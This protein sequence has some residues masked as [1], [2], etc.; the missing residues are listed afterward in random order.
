MATQTSKRPT[1]NELDRALLQR[2]DQVQ[3]HLDALRSCLGDGQPASTEGKAA[4][5]V[6]IGELSRK[7]Q[8]LQRLLVPVVETG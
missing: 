1:G 6:K 2:I 5:L 3:E 4:A 7:L 8:Q